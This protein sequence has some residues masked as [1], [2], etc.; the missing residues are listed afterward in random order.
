MNVVSN[1]FFRGSMYVTKLWL[2][3]NLKGFIVIV[4]YE[5]LIGFA[6]FLKRWYNVAVG[7]NFAMFGQLR[8]NEF[9]L[10]KHCVVY[11]SFN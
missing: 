10:L 2:R 7:L 11:E 3:P 1:L 9:G 6:I 8:C 4:G 5:S